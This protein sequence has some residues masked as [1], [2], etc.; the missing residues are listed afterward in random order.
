M[1]NH[2]HLLALVDPSK[3]SGDSA[4]EMADQTLKRGGRVT[5]LFLLSGPSAR[6]LA[7]FAASEGVGI[8]EAAEVYGAQ[9][10]QAL[11]G[12]DRVEVLTS[13]GDDLATTLPRVARSVA[14]TSMVV[15]VS[16]TKERP[17]ARFVFEAD[18]PVTVVPNRR[19]A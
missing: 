11:G 14:A 3:R 13:Y 15:P 2:E 7:D 17:V 9:I 18:L 8:G 10:K 19:A 16:M 12:A 1:T 4:L 6:S 5:V